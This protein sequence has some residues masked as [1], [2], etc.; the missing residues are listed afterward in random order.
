M[1]DALTSTARLSHSPALGRRELL[2]LTLGA[3]GVVYGNIGTSPLYAMREA[4]HGPWAV[5]VR[6]ENVLGVLSLMIWALVLVI[7]VKYLVVLLRADHQ[8]QGGIIALLTILIPS[9]GSSLSRTLAGITTLSLFGAALLYGDGVITPA[10]SVLSA[11]EGLEVTAPGLTRLVI[12]LTLAILIGL[13]AVQSRGTGRIGAVF[14]P[15]VLVWF[16]A[17]AAVG[18]WG[19]VREPQVLAAF[20][21][22]W[23]VRFFAGNGA[24]GF[25]VLSAVVLVVTG[26]EALYADLGHFGKTP[27]RLAGFLVALPALVLN[28][29]GQGALLLE[30]PEAAAAPFYEL[31]PFWARMPM[32]I[33]ATAA[34]VVASQALITACYSLTQQ[35]VNLGYIPRV[36]IIHTSARVE[37]QIYV[38]QVNT[39][40]MLSCVAVVLL[41]G[42]SSRMAAAYGLAVV[43]TMGVTTVLF[44][45][46]AMREWRWG[47]LR[48]GALAGVFAL[49]EAA[50]F[51]ANLMKLAHGAWIPLV[52]G[53]FLYV[54]MSTWRRG[55]DL[56][57]MNLSSEA[58]LPE[59]SL[60]ADLAA[61]KVSRVPG[62]AVFMTRLTRGL[63]QVLL[64]H[65]KHNRVL[66][67][68][69]ILMTVE[70]LAVPE[71]RVPERLEVIDLGE[72]LYRVVLRHGFMETP[73]IAAALA[74]QPVGGEPVDLGRT[75]FYLGRETILPSGSGR[76]ARWRKR[77][78]G[79]M[80]RNAETATLFYGLPP[81]RVVELGTQVAL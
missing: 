21:P 58:A 54:L 52:V 62:T 26:G 42:D 20:N 30:R 33:L 8:G 48:A 36:R 11:V 3:V 53:L 4:F 32:V 56:L 51:G 49:I 40:L 35:L 43:G 34:T 38:P 18:F 22:A 74:S 10:M 61:K 15:I 37:G 9:G 47:P 67:Q 64:H 7:A 14:G 25:L 55:R 68:R 27:I 23:A 73:R 66:H 77:L 19:V 71:V 72:G 65:L 78:F 2:A 57:A 28:Y 24:M 29:L 41:F 59:T 12:P 63:P 75:S 6:P 69:V 60:V 16:V 17:I 76:M 1:N 46:V 31:V 70:S 45:F 81:N 79:L 50:L 5:A 44:Y 39:F 80:A 13:F